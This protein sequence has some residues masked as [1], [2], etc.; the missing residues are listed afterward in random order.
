MCQDFLRLHVHSVKA[1]CQEKLATLISIFFAQSAQF[2]ILDTRK[3]EKY[4]FLN[5]T[6]KRDPSQKESP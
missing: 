6:L 5:V 2:P 3:P 1:D 4:S